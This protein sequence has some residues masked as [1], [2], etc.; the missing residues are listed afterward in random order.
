MQR[1]GETLTPWIFGMMDIHH[2]NT[3]R[4]DASFMI[5]PD[6]TTMLFD[7]GAQDPTDERVNSPRN[8]PAVPNEDRLPGE[9]VA[10]YVQHVHPDGNDGS[11]VSVDYTVLSHFHDDHIGDLSTVSPP[12]LLGNYSLTGITEAGEYL[13]LRK[14]IDRG[15]PDYDYPVPMLSHPTMSNYKAFLDWQVKHNG[16]IVE[17][18]KAGRN[19]QILLAREPRRYPTFE[20]RNVVS[21]G[22]VWTG[23]ASNTRSIFPPIEHLDPTQYPSE[24][25]CSIGLRISYGKFDYFNGGDITGVLEFDSPIWFDVETPVAQVVGPVEVNVLDHH[26]NRSSV[27]EYFLRALRPRVH[28]I[29]VWSSDHPGFGVLKRILSEKLYPGPRDV[30]ATSMLEPNRLVIG[31][32]LN[33][34]AS[35]RGH[36]L[37]RVEPGGEWYRVIVLDDSAETFAVTG[38]FGPYESR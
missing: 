30:F 26:G 10:R 1:T 3:G 23:V 37:V 6:G 38:V 31:D 11:Q 8:T 36:I 7:V 27:N 4:G 15:F 20:V 16:A 25:M 14:I 33:R 5:F 18:F 9:W 21:N 35:N 29:P 2:I 17:Q 24:N 22:E 19:D 13:R 34:L 12:S 32:M 28:I